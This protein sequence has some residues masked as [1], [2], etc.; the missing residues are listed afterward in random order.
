VAIRAANVHVVFNNNYEDQGQ[1][2]A[3]TL[4][5]FIG[6]SSVAGAR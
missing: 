4:R 5:A 6:P 3:R 2:K 1:R